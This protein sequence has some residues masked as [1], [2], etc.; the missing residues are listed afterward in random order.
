M[1]T[2][3]IRGALDC[4]PEFGNLFDTY[5]VTVV[6]EEESSSI[7]VGHVTWKISFVCHLFLRRGG[8]IVCT[9]NGQRRFSS[10]LAQ[11]GL[12]VPCC[13]TFMGAMKEV[14]KVKKL[15]DLAPA[16]VPSDK[17]IVEEPPLKK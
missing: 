15:I 11:R 3:Y 17:A 8:H 16:D 1:W 6:K 10:D 14:E 7:T 9:V 4:K 5:A 2:P 12:E 13:Y